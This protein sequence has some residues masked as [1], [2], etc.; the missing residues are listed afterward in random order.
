MRVLLFFG[1]FTFSNAARTVEKAKGGGPGTQTVFLI[2]GGVGFDVNLLS[3]TPQ[4]VKKSKHAKLSQHAVQSEASEIDDE[5]KVA[6]DLTLKLQN[7]ADSSKKL[8]Q[9]VRK[10]KARTMKA[11]KL[12]SE[13][14]EEIKKIQQKV[15]AKDKTLENKNK[16]LLHDRHENEL[17]KKKVKDLEQDIEVSNHA[18][19]EAADHEKQV[20]EEAKEEAKEEAAKN[21]RLSQQMAEQPK[22]KVP[23]AGGKAK[24][25]SKKLMKSVKKKSVKLAKAAKDDV[26]PVVDTLDAVPSADEMAEMESAESDNTA[27]D[28][29]MADAE[30]QTQMP[31]EDED[32]PVPEDA[33]ETQETV[34]KPPMVHATR[35]SANVEG[36]AADDS[37]AMPSP[38]EEANTA[39]EADTEDASMATPEAGNG[40]DSSW[41][42]AYSPAERAATVEE[43]V[44]GGADSKQPESEDVL[45]P[46]PNAPEPVEED[47]DDPVAAKPDLIMGRV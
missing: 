12:L 43:S 4:T 35:N 1:I 13:K 15:A 46:N 42:L 24:Q 16:M 7:T 19:K 29:G 28:D 40:D 36:E 10:L 21:D 11:E 32:M 14:D 26:P 30:E 5:Q 34:V 47:P 3:T 25:S 27:Q 9:Q 33:E 6:A 44:E 37:D 22:K 45:S 18:W 17:L 31:A 20:A 23:A 8:E 2:K 41:D 39:A 38:T